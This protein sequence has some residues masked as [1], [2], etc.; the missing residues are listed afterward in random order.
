[1][2]RTV[3]IALLLSRLL[4]ASDGT[5]NGQQVI[6]EARSKSDIRELS[7]F[8]LK[9]NVKIQN[10]DKVLSG[11][12]ALVWN[13]PNQWREELAVPGFDQIRVGGVGTVAVKRDFDFLPLRIFQ[14]QTALAYG[15][16]GW[17]ARGD[18]RIKHVRVRK[19]NGVDARCAEISGKEFTREICMDSS[20]GALIRDLPFVDKEFTPVGTKIFPHF[21]S[22]VVGGDTVA[23]AEIT[24]LSTTESISP[25][26]FE[27]PPGAISKAG[28][29]NPEP[30]RLIKKSPP[31]Y[32]DIA[33]QARIQ[34]TVA[35]YGVIGTDGSLHNMRIISGIPAL[36]KASLDAVEQWRYEPYMCQDTPIEVE[37]VIQVNFALR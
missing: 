6:E 34:G 18:E 19:V 16:G 23:E 11:Q 33:K 4:L 5:P 26:S 37:S 20:S 10:Q 1:M 15:N 24:E 9:A 2:N 7:S 28:C 14:L 3:L 32:P 30:G 29:L 17:T 22:Y 27:V 36:N 25:S 31:Q 13:G 35:I 21:L 12:Y 8:T